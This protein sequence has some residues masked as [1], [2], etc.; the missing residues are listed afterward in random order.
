VTRAPRQSAD[1]PIAKQREIE[2]LFEDGADPRH[3]AARFARHDVNQ[4][5]ETRPRIPHAWNWAQPARPAA[6]TDG[7]P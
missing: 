7:A 5:N 6:R 4:P 2:A 1:D 3:A